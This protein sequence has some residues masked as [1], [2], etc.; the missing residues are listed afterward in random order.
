MPA[1]SICVRSWRVG[2]CG[3]CMS[4]ASGSSAQAHACR[5]G[6][7]S[8]L[9]CEKMEHFPRVQSIAGSLTFG[10]RM[11]TLWGRALT[12]AALTVLLYCP[13]VHSTYPAAAPAWLA[14]IGTATSARHG[15]RPAHSL[16]VAHRPPWPC[17]AQIT[18][19]RKRTD[20][21]PDDYFV[22]LVGDMITEEALPTYMA[23]LNT[24]DGVR[25]ETGGA[26][27]AWGR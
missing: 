7:A 20:C 13:C 23:M 3:C 14:Q 27:S 16:A 2:P 22:V 17:C 9:Q 26:P 12:A 8:L 1:P 5:T 19:L 24:L 6:Y 15:H 4:W 11:S 21:L 25:D 18:E 10:C